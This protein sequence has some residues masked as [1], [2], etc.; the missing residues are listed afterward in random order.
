MSMSDP[1][2]DYL[3]IIRNSLAIK[4]DEVSASS[5]KLKVEIAK[6]LKQEGYVRDFSVAKEG[7]RETLKVLLKYDAEG[8]SVIRELKRVSKPG[9]RT[10][11]ST[12]EIPVYRNGIGT[13]IL[14]T[15]QGVMTDRQARREKIGGE[16]LCSVW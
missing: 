12:K 16:L 9:C 10:Y 7:K 4:R 13:Y 11:C 6:V 1:I 3:T 14:T 2:A 5:S 8:R 15:P